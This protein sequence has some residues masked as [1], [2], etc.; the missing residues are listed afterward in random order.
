MKSSIMRLALCLVAASL[1]CT[2]TTSA[3]GDDAGTAEGDGGSGGGSGGSGGGSGG[4]GGG[5]GGSGGGSGGSGGGS[6]GS[7][8]GSGDPVVVADAGAGVFCGVEV[9]EEGMCCADPFAGICGAPIGERGCLIPSPESTSSDPR[10]PS[11]DVMGFFTIPSCCTEDGQCGVDGTNFNMGCIELGMAAEGAM[12]MGG[13][14]SLIEWP[15]PQ[16]CE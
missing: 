3:G 10:C 14:A 16:P 9:C 1:G 15:P 6:G 7:G 4:S 8:G 5:S 2:E 13:G 12:M 11:V